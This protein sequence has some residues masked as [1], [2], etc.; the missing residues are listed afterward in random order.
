MKLTD[1]VWIGALAGLSA[2][3]LWTILNNTP[4]D[5]LSESVWRISTARPLV[6]FVAGFL[7]GHFFF[8]RDSKNQD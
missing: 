2:Y 6:P 1:R 8:Q 4:G 7:C 3:E 5:T